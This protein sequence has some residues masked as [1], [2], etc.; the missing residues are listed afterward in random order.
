[1]STPNDILDFWF[2]GIEDGMPNKARSRFWF[3]PPPGTD[4]VIRE[5]FGELHARASLGA[6]DDWLDTAHGRLAAILLIDQFSRNIHRGTPMAFANDDRALRWCKAGLDAGHDRELNLAERLFYYLPLEHSES[7]SDQ[8]QSVAC[9]QSL[10][11]EQ[12]GEGKK[13][14][15][16]SLDYALDHREIIVQ[17]GRFPHRN[18]TL[19]RESSQEERAYLADGGKR[20]G[21]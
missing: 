3:M 18:K 16:G 6:I 21:Q 1:M 5:R 4:D 13:W 2:D 7:L 9:F 14:A 17:F 12:E 15:Q 8:D 11:D 19:G 10:V 20:F